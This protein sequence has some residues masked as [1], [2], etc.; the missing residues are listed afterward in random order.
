MAEKQA[1]VAVQLMESP[2]IILERTVL[3]V[4]KRS[5]NRP[6][7]REQVKKVMLGIDNSKDATLLHFG[8]NVG[9]RVSEALSFNQDAINWQEGTVKIYD[10]KKNTY[11]E[12]MP[13]L[14]TLNKLKQYIND[15][16]P[17]GNPIFNFGVKTAERIAQKWIALAIGEPRSWHTLRHT[18]V[19]LSNEAHQD[20]KIVMMNTGDSAA[21]I[22]KYY[23]TLSPDY[24]RKATEEKPVYSDG[25]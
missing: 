14:E 2:K 7:S 19:S 5:P 21:T 1:K 11:R 18:Y 8:F 24:R 3:K 13:P 23:T 15:T 6:L 20:I 10:E 9:C 12:V 17:G 4:R 25:H 22:L 16:K